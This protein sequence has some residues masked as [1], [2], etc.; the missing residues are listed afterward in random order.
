MK[1]WKKAVGV[2]LTAVMVLSAVSVPAGAK[3]AEKLN[4]TDVSL[5]V[6]ESVSLKVTGTKQKATWSSSD[7]SVAAVTKSGKVTAKKTGKATVSAKLKKK[8]L[9][10]S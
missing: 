10:Q 4:K 8:T 6:G 5:A 9:K 7:K 1:M 2:L 3:S